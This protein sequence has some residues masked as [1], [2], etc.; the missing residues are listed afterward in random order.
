MPKPTTLDT[1]WQ[2]LMSLCASESKFKSEGDHARL[3]KLLQSDID[4]LAREMGFSEH[5]IVT[6]DFRAVRDGDHI[7]RIIKE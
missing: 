6:R 5:L 3:L 1:Q 2:R 4:L 7:I